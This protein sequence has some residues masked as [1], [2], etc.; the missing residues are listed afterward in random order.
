MSHEYRPV[1]VGNWVMTMLLMC[2]PFINIILLF[3]WAFGSNTEV[4]KAN[5]A[6]ATLVW[7]LLG[8]IIWIF[9]FFVFGVGA[10]LLSATA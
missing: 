6:K 7:F 10:A 9:L 4:S 8:F 2:I 3:V 5:W 1:S